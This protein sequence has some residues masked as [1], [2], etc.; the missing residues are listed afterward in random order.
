MNLNENDKNNKKSFYDSLT[1]EFS[2]LAYIPLI[3]LTIIITL[4]GVTLVGRALNNEAEDGMVDL[5][6]SINIA[7]DQLYPGDYN[8]SE[9]NGEI[10]FFKGDHQINGEFDYIDSIK[11]ATGCDVTFCYM[12]YVVITT[13]MDKDGNR[14]IGSADSSEVVKDVI[15]NKESRFYSNAHMGDQTYV[16]YYEPLLDEKDDV[17]GMICIAKP[18]DSIKKLTKSTIYPII[19]IA[20]ITMLIATFFI[21]KYSEGF[22]NAIKHIQKYLKAIA[23]GDFRAELDNSV[24]KRVDE[25]GDIGKNASKMAVSLRRQVEE[26][27]LTGLLNRR[28]ADKKIKA[29]I[30]DYNQKGVTFNV[31][32]GDIDFF[33]KVNDTYGHDA[34]DAVLVAVAN[35]LK[36]TMIGNGYAIRWGGE[37][38]I[39]IFENK[40]FDQ[41]E[42]IL[43]HM[44]D[45]IRAM[46][47]VSGEY[48]IKVTMTF[49]L[50]EC[51]P[52]INTYDKYI[53]IADE[54]LYY[55]K[56]HGRN[57]LV[58]NMPDDG[59]QQ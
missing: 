10:Y 11:E 51:S 52:E 53:T 49:G 42:G 38:F 21:Y 22:L 47:V 13:F 7:V 57:Q 28:S 3:L 32:M 9:S 59:P 12:N 23:N 14:I 27:Q 45:E 8:V 5:C 19:L 46:E 24:S 58:T 30:N 18:E 25:L 55:G 39:L 26:D 44:L 31:A 29:T 43:L 41:S 17:I 4:V 6:S 40:S 34:G 15:D 20:L 50:T 33:K 16:V 54:K 56:Q 35:T 37:E 48:T 36:K 2:K 1:W